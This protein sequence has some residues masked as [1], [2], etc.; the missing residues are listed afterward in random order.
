MRQAMYTDAISVTVTPEMKAA[1]IMVSE[2]EEVGQSE[3][4]RRWLAEGFR[5]DRGPA[6]TQ[7]R[8]ELD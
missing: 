7:A 3:V 5:R 2:T 4:V 6:A 8:Q 1:I